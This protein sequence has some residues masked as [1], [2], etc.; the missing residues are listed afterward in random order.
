MLPLFSSLKKKISIIIFHRELKLNKYLVFSSSLYLVKKKYIT[1]YMLKTLYLSL[2]PTNF[3]NS[4]FKNNTLQ[5]F[6]NNFLVYSFFLYQ[7][8]ISSFIN[9]LNLSDILKISFVKVNNLYFTNY[10]KYFLKFSNIYYC[11]NTLNN[12]LLNL[13]SNLKIIINTFKS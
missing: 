13:T 4:S 9:N 12:L 6:S 7:K 2:F 5:N 11:F 3:L 1:N 8:E 10:Y